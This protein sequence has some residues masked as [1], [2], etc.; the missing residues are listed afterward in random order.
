MK[1]VTCLLW[2]VAI[3]ASSLDLAHTL[4]PT[5]GN[6]MI[7]GSVPSVNNIVT[8]MATV[9]PN[10]LINNKTMQ[11][12][13]KQ[14][15]FL[16]SLKIDNIHV[17]NVAINK[18]Q[19]SFLPGT[20]TLRIVFSDVD[21][22]TTIKG[23]IYALW[24]IPMECSQMNVTGFSFSMDLEV[25]NETDGVRWQLK[26]VSAL[27]LKD[28]VFTTTSGFFN[29]VIKLVHGVMV[30]IAKKELKQA[31]SALDMWVADLNNALKISNQTYFLGNLFDVK[32]PM[33]FTSTAAPMVDTAN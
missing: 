16:Y 19:F 32:I 2:T 21:I 18:R 13:V 33:N 3:L 23:A 26:S 29:Y 28:I 5:P 15:G 17:E 20:N 11:I 27:D 25:V 8:L 7:S 31:K 9:L 22:T 1:S 30:D 4:E 6:L 10:Y 14:S 12:D 24:F